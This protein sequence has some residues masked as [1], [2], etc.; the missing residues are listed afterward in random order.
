M[1]TGVGPPIPGAPRGHVRDA[2]NTHPLTTRA[3]TLGLGPLPAIFGP[4]PPHKSDEAGAVLREGL[5]GGPSWGWP[6]PFPVSLST[7][8]SAAPFTG[9]RGRWCGPSLV[10]SED[11]GWRVHSQHFHDRAVR[12]PYATGRG[13]ALRR[14]RDPGSL[15]DGGTPPH[16]PRTGRLPRARPLPPRPPPSDPH[17][18][19]LDEGMGSPFGRL[20]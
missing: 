10:S 11:V 7:R 5:E 15:R 12:G 2:R 6:Q 8:P 1:G 18:R 3:H 16:G 14:H 9:P 17:E 19:E 4:L 13:P 20:T